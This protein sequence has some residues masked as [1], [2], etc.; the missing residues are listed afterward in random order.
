MDRTILHCD[1]NG[2]YASVECL[3]RPELKDVPMA[4]CGS[5][6]NRHGIILAK[7][8]LAKGF[9]VV[10]AETVWQAKKKCPGLTLVPPHH[11]RYSK[12]SKIVNKI[13]DRYTDLVEPFGIDESW[14]DVTGSLHLFGSGKDIADSIRETVK[15]EAGLTVSVG[16]SF[17]KVFSKLGSDYKKPDATT[18]I[19]RDNYKEIVFPLHVSNLLYAG[20]AA[21]EA[22]E[23]LGITTI[24]Q[25]ARADRE[26][27]SG[28]LGKLGA[29]LHD[30]ASGLDE[31][32]VLPPDGKN[33]TKSVGNGM[34]FRR[35][36]IGIDDIRTGIL[37]LSESVAYRLR[38]YG[39]KCGTVQVTIRDP[40]FKTITRQK[41]LLR[42]THLMKEI[43]E[44]ALKII[45]ERWNLN[46]PIR[47]LTVTGMNLTAGDSEQISFFGDSDE[48]QRKKREKLEE[49]LDNI[50]GRY[51][52]G[53]ILLGTSLDNDLGIG[54]HEEEGDE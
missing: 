28:K 8:E 38:K 19:S 25:L 54:T 3:Y 24:G 29:M 30:Y 18:I 34:T 15:K 14:L 43:S 32:P 35:N 45:M 23:K 20:R 47:M 36:L 6:E 21:S 27:V 12:Y 16:V 51:G 26:I 33:D 46:S 37:A 11:D 13:Y 48:R 7:N 40:E 39:Y 49:T 4:V 52:R 42:P 50:R 31:S 44:A 9:G 1:L 10:T 53:S 5:V 22:L 17:N 41:K 2:F